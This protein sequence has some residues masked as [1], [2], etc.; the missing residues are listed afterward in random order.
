MS[1]VFKVAHK[2]RA[3]V[4][5]NRVVVYSGNKKVGTYVVSKK[6]TKPNKFMD[7]KN[8]I[9]LNDIDELT[10]ASNELARKTS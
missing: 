5:P 9:L 7:T 4:F 3:T 1:G 8:S 10:E 6:Y 2:L